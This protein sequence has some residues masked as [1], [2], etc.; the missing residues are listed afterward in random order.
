MSRPFTGRGIRAFYAEIDAHEAQKR[1]RASQDGLGERESIGERPHVA[2]GL[3][4]YER[5]PR[6]QATELV[7]AATLEQN[8]RRQR[9][10]EV[11]KAEIDLVA[12]LLYIGAHDFELQAAIGAY[13]IDVYF[14]AERLAVEVDGAEFHES[15]RDRTRDRI[16]LRRYGIATARLPAREV[17]RDP[18]VAA[19][20][21]AAA[22]GQRRAA[23]QGAP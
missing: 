14:P 19:Q 1:R 2:G 7:T 13:D 4:A 17:W 12:G 6:A 5:L 3:L 18:V 22:V 20:R 15:A 11:S 23:I 10:A 9:Q 16:L 21:V 8:D